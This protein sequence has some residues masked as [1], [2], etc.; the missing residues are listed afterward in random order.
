VSDSYWQ[1]S[2]ETILEDITLTDE[3]FSQIVEDVA[4]SASM[5][6]EATGQ[7]HIP[8]P[9]VAEI[10]RITTAHHKDEAS[11]EDREA[12]YR[13]ELENLRYTIRRLRS[14]LYDAENQ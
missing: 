14:D 13:E 8:H 12:K 7:E 3:Q 4:H 9:S 10:E 11:W 5:E 1:T 2:L 6:W